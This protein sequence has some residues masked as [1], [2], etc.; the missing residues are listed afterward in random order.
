MLGDGEIRTFEIKSWNSPTA[1]RI[2]NVF[3]GPTDANE[4]TF[5]I[6]H[7]RL[8]FR[9]ECPS[10]ASWQ[11]L[12]KIYRQTLIAKTPEVIQFPLILPDKPWLDIALGTVDDGPVTFQ[13]NIL[14]V[15]GPTENVALLKRTITTPN[16]WEPVQVDLSQYAR[17]NIILSLS[18]AGDKAGTLGFWGSPVIRN[19]GA[20]PQPSTI[21]KDAFSRDTPQG[22]I[23]IWADDLRWNHLDAYGY[24]RQTAPVL[25]RMAEEGALFHDCLSQG[26]WTLPSTASLFTSLYPTTHGVYAEGVNATLLPASAT[27]LTEVFH[28]AGHATLSFASLIYT[29]AMFNL[30]QGFE[31]LHEGRST[32]E[33]PDSS[34]EYIGRLLGWLDE[35][36]EVL[37][38]IPA[39]R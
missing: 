26:P 18:L 20:I 24:S 31:E 15:D 29:G 36:R 37:F 38:R 19:N 39:C 25:R 35:H 32:V 34:R 17:Q 9:K 3:V 28:Q 6:E 5:E 8:I 14:S 13:V 33:G 16:R 10:G 7:I 27:T 4:A 30:D 11:G 2:K 22:I 23:L 1:S 21:E 12:S